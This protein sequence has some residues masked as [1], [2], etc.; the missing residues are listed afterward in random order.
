MP[1][2][3]SPL[4]GLDVGP[5]KLGAVQVDEVRNLLGVKE[6]PLP[7]LFDP[8]HKEVGDP[9]G[10]VDVV[11]TTSVVAGVVPQLEEIKDVGVPGL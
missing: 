10:D 8:L 2:E 3:E 11:G 9:V 1:F 6:R 7:I 5:L 4:F